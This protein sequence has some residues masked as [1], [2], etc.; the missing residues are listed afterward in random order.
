MAHQAIVSPSEKGDRRSEQRQISVLRLARL[1]MPSGTQLCRITNVS[2]S[3]LQLTVFGSMHEGTEVTI[4]VPDQL[5]IHGKVA[6]VDGR[7]AGI[8]VEAGIDDG[9]LMRLSETSVTPGRRRRTPR[10]AVQ[11]A[12]CLRVQGRSLP[13]ELVDLS[14]SGA[15]IGAAGRDLSV[16][17]ATL[18]ILGLPKLP[19]Q[20]RWTR[21]EQAGLSFNDPLQVQ[22]L[23]DWLWKD[24]A[25]GETPQVAG[26]AA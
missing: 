26:E 18:D 3:G 19:A 7:S 25:A 22:L 11:V 20:I 9:A 1:E 14:P 15:M 23:A 21:G 5:V 6:W 13:V 24:P 17:P 12:C 2:R 10:V 4:H 16:G 8:K